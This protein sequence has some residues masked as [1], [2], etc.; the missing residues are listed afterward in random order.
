MISSKLEQTALHSRCRNS[1]ME[2]STWMRCTGMLIIPGSLK[3]IIVLRFG[4]MDGFPKAESSV[5]LHN[6]IIV[7]IC[8][9]C[10]LQPGIYGWG[11]LEAK[12]ELEQDR[13]WVELEQ[14]KQIEHIFAGS[15]SDLPGHTLPWCTTRDRTQ[16]FLED[17]GPRHFQRAC[18]TLLGYRHGLDEL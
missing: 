18:V 12:V 3:D 17:C 5:T 2:E 16:T 13:T 1:F 6:I 15:L 4:V 7:H 9:I 11:V 14:G 10:L 8:K